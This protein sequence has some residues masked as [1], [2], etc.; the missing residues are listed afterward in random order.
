MEHGVRRRVG[1]AVVLVAQLVP[2]RQVPPGSI[3]W[4]RNKATYPAS[5]SPVRLLHQSSP[6]TVD[7]AAWRWEGVA[8][9]VGVGVG[10][11]ATGT[12]A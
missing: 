7:K 11:P 5:G 9:G 1:R 10:V 3:G 6:S 4:A 2:T 12:M 8:V